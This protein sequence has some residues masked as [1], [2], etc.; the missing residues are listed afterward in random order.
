MYIGPWQEYNLSRGKSSSST[1]KAVQQ[2]KLKKDLEQAL[3]STLDPNAARAAMKVMETILQQQQQPIAPSSLTPIHHY[4]VINSDQGKVFSTTTTLENGEINPQRPNHH[5]R[6][7]KQRSGKRRNVHLPPL[8]AAQQR[9]FPQVSSARNPSGASPLSVRST[10]S[11]PVKLPSLSVNPAPM[12]S[13]TSIGS[14]DRNPNEVKAFIFP[15]TQHNLEKKLYHDNVQQESFMDAGNILSRKSTDSN[16][17]SQQ[18]V[19]DA[20]ALINFLKMERNNQR[21]KLEI[22]KIAGWNRSDKSEGQT[23][24]SLNSGMDNENNYKKF[25]FNEE[26]EKK[27]ELVKQMKDIY[28]HRLKDCSGSKSGA[29]I[30]LES[31]NSQESR[32]IPSI[33][34]IHSPRV[35]D[36]DITEDDLLRVSKYFKALE[37]TSYSQQQPHVQSS[38]SALIASTTLNSTSPVIQKTS[39]VALC[40]DL[41]SDDGFE[42]KNLA[43]HRSMSADIK[44]NGEVAMSKEYLADHNPHD[45]LY[46]DDYNGGLDSL[47]NWTKGLNLDDL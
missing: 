19:Y 6:G 28:L 10:Q 3:T 20:A 46:M 41:G 33:S 8:A 36:M 16:A 40:D 30:P 44:E 45:P 37:S 22:S 42:R 25:K 21:A 2:E 14:R 38:K 12:N 13:Y 32:P 23:V 43:I 24:V 47:L 17:K 34:P 4:T 9:L 18:P 7:S 31:N 29:E 11:E 35:V 5:A 26:K 27:I 1:V 15:L 39:Y